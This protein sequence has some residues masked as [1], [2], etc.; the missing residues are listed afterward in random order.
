MPSG[1]PRRRRARPVSDAPVDALLLRTEDLAKGWLLALLED[2]PLD[3]APA[4]LAADLARQGPRVCGAVLRALASDEDLRRL[5]PNGMLEPLVAEVGVFAGADTVAATSRAVQ[6]LGAIIWAA[7]RAELSW[8]DPDLVSELAER[9][10][11][12]LELVREAAL[13]EAP[14]SLGEAPGSSGEAPGSSGEAPGSLHAVAPP[15][16]DWEA[17]AQGSAA[18]D[19]AADEQQAAHPP[20]PAEPATEARL[21]AVEAEADRAGPLWKSALQDEI[22]RSTRTGAPLSLLLVELEEADRVRAV[23]SP[24]EASS[25]FGRFAQAVRGAVRRQ[26]ILACET[27][28]RAWIIARDT[29]RL[30]AQALAARVAGAVGGMQPWRGAPMNVS[31]GLALL[32]DDGHDGDTLIEAAEE[33][34][35]AASASGAGFAAGTEPDADEPGQAVAR[36]P[37]GDG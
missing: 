2:A 9:L 32:R 28:S 25:T 23:A 4:I 34:R 11:L 26:D 37:D 1:A 16:A 12:V 29:G 21:A 5:E 15:G 27:D 20:R 36:E 35:F 24:L 13:R 6:A 17:L 10:S 7:L 3:D 31:V 8:T 30:G 14:G 19:A 18:P 22:S 33:A